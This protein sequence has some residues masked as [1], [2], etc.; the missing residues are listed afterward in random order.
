MR[1]T[2]ARAQLVRYVSLSFML[3]LLAFLKINTLGKEF[4]RL[5]SSVSKLRTHD[6]S[7]PRSDTID[8]G[9]LSVKLA[10]RQSHVPPLRT[11]T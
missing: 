2:F 8:L 4:Y 9:T 5:S 11:T 6:C 1:R 3:L 10:D 7:Y